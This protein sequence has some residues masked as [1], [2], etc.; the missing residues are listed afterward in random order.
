MLAL[1][2]ACRQPTTPEIQAIVQGST[3]VQ[4]EVL[5][6]LPE[7][8]APAGGT[9]VLYVCKVVFTNTGATDVTPALDHFVFTSAKP[10][11]ATYRPLTSGIPPAVT[12]SNP[13][14]A[15]RAG[16]KQE[17][18]LVFRPATGATGTIAYQ[19]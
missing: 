4:V 7:A 8:E 17:Y 19:P 18:T 14:D 3:N 6:I 5:Q 2:T 13:A 15:V 11:R 1:L 10:Q 9:A 12:I 16:D